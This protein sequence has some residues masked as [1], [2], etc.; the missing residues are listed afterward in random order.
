MPVLNITNNTQSASGLSDPE[1]LFFE[2]VVPGA[3]AFDLTSET[4]NNLEVQLDE[5][6]ARTD[7]NG[8]AKFDINVSAGPLSGNDD[9]SGDETLS[10]YLANKVNLDTVV[11]NPSTPSTVSSRQVDIAA[12]EAMVDGELFVYVA[13]TDEAGDAEIDKDG[14]NVS[15][16]DLETDEDVYTHVLMVNNA[17][18]REV[19]LV[20]GD[21][22]DNAGSDDASPLND[23]QLAAAVGAYLSAGGP[24]YGFV[25]IAAV[26]FEEST[27]LT[28]T[29]TSLRPAPP[30]YS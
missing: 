11:T 12:G 7:D 1:T 2:Q 16:V 25:Q 29:T 20:R 3:N 27:G 21:G 28:Q 8:D 13:S 4:L 26:L 24:E 5:L 22:V 17:G 23:A 18:T 19:V 15:A 6:A 14:V 30:A 10:H 9:Y